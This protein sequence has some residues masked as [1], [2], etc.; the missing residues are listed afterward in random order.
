[1]A[2]AR[3]GVVHGGAHCFVGPRGPGRARVRGVWGEFRELAGPY[4]LPISRP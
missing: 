3:G 4:S 1:M 2:G